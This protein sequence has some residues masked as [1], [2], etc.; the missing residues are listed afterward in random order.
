MTA[1]SLG[2][3]LPIAAITG[4]VEIMDAPGP[5]G[6]GGTFAGNPLS[7]E[8]ALA[9]LDFFE[10]H[11]LNERASQLGNQFQERA[12]RWHSRWPKIGNVRGLGAMQ[13]LELVQSRET[14]EPAPEDTKKVTKYCYEHGVITISAGSYG[15]VIRLLMPLV[16]TDEQMQE[17]LDV[18]EAA[19][20][21]VYEA[22]RPAAQTV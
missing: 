22:K 18:L 20:H 13:A 12:R 9:V 10:Q 5:G 4:R 16:I 6:L 21:A 3:G 2:G 15:N 1:K 17:A 8:A 7:C 19:F 11:N 14:K